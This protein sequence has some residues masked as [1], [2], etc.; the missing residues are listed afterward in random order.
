M[1]PSFKPTPF[2]PRVAVLRDS[3]PDPNARN[4]GNIFE[5]L[6]R[7]PD[8]NYRSLLN[9]GYNVI[10]DRYR[11]CS[12]VPGWQITISSND[13]TSESEVIATGRVS[14]FGGNL[15]FFLDGM[16][17]PVRRGRLMLRD[18]EGNGWFKMNSD[19]EKLH[20]KCER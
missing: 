5:T 14:G 19:C 10:L 16:D 1:T 2:V 17:K 13:S 4:Q 20:A 7:S 15:E 3:A 9:A 18:Q 8:R 11:E 12:L 6:I